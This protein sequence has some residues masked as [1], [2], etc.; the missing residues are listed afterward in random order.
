MDGPPPPRHPRL[1][2]SCFD[3]TVACMRFIDPNENV[4]ISSSCKRKIRKKLFR[5]RKEKE[6]GEIGWIFPS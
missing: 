4:Y 5:L 1:H 3:S 6:E 2:P